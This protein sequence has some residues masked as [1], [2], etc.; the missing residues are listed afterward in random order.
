MS[1]HTVG[2]SEMTQALAE[3]VIRRD[4]LPRDQA[5]KIHLVV[6]CEILQLG[7]GPLFTLHLTSV[8]LSEGGDS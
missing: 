4:R 7:D 3:F 2:A 6:N 5:H 1:S 8:P